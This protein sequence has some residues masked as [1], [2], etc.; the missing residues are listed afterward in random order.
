MT[1]PRCGVSQMM[2]RRRQQHQSTLESNRRAAATTGGDTTRTDGPTPPELLF[3]YDPSA[4]MIVFET[5]RVV[6]AAMT[7]RMAEPGYGGFAPAPERASAFA[8]P[9][10]T[11]EFPHWPNPG[12]W[13]STI[14]HRTRATAHAT[15]IA[16]AYPLRL[17]ILL[18]GA[19]RL[20]RYGTESP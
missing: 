17:T 4:D 3:S 9:G 1:L 8:P 10:E 11:G 20:P 13:P 18:L 19:L 16:L 15:Q 14:V 7:P 5:K 2:R 6:P 12:R